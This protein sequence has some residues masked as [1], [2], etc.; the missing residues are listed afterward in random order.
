MGLFSHKK[1]IG[2]IEIRLYGEDVARVSYKSDI[3]DRETTEQNKMNLFVMYFSKILFNLG[4]RREA[5]KLIEDM[6][7]TSIETLKGAI[8][9]N[10]NDGSVAI[11]KSGIKRLNLLKDSPK[12]VDNEN[13]KE[14]DKFMKKIVFNA[15]EGEKLQ[16]TATN[17]IKLYKGELYGKSD[18]SKIIQ[19]SMSKGEE[20]LYAP[21]SV[22]VFFQYLINNLSVE[23]LS[24]LMSVL[25]FMR[26][27]YKEVGDYTDIASITKASDYGFERANDFFNQ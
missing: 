4:K 15:P 26:E 5:D 19:T 14:I 27:Y 11:I 24:Y 16:G 8:A 10:E 2:S 7:Q 18:E 1:L 6:H 12:L 22:M 20:E 13:A 23:T 21:L 25:Q 17:N 9:K 3:T